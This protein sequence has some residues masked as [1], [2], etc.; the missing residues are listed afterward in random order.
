[1]AVDQALLESADAGPE[2]AW[3]RVYRWAVPTLSLG[4]FQAIAEVRESPRWA[5]LPVV[6]RPSGG[7]A[8]LHDRE[9]TYAVVVPRS[10]PLAA[11]PAALYRAVHEAIAAWL[12]SLGWPAHRRSASGDA[13]APPDGAA[14]P[15]LCFLDRDPEDVVVGGVKVVGGAQR[16]RP[17]AVLQ[18][19]ALLLGTSTHAAELTGLLDL[20]A[21][22]PPVPETDV[23]PGLA[24]AVA[25]ALGLAAEPE[26][27]PGWLDGAAARWSAERY[28]A[29]A[30]TAR[31]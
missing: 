24:A 20:G 17:G 1:M 31:R 11:R 7:G 2:D 3:L 16:R 21:P 29:E 18:H 14:R 26:E 19:G 12:R 22:T 13:A 27:W 25:G 5:G 15:F 9:L 28:A 23:E 8:L 30:W 6:R 10:H 4:Y